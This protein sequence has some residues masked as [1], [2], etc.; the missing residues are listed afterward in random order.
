MKSKTIVFTIPL[1]PK[2]KKNSMQPRLAKGERPA[3][4]DGQGWG[5]GRR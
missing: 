4:C 2:T 1:D 5:A 3:G